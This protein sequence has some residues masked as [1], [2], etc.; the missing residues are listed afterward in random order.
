MATDVELY[1]L[2]KAMIA[3]MWAWWRLYRATNGGETADTATAYRL[4]ALRQ[5]AREAKYAVLEAKREEH[6]PAE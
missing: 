4:W 2:R 3:A 1:E 5:A 6:L